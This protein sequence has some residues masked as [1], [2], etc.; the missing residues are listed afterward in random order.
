MTLDQAYASGK[1][2]EIAYLDGHVE[3]GIV[4]KNHPSAQ[5]RIFILCKRRDSLG[6]Y[7]IHQDDIT[8]IT[9]V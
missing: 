1:R 8:S 6:G 9:L 4:R 2:V 3:R 7:A 5:V